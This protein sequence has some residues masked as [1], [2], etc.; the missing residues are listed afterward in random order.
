VLT[1]SPRSVDRLRITMHAAQ[2]HAL[3]RAALVGAGLAA[4]VVAHITAVGAGGPEILPIAPLIWCALIALAVVCG[5]R[6]EIYAPRSAVGT[7]AALVAA[8]MVF[9]A[10]ASLAPWALG[11]AGSGMRMSG[12]AMLTAG[13]VWPHALAA[14]VLGAVLVRA[15]R[16]LERA[17]AL[18]RRAVA[19]LAARHA[20]PRPERVFRT[21]RITLTAQ[22]A[23]GSRPARGPPRLRNAAAA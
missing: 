4:T 10:V 23:G 12:I 11:F 2:A 16:L 5:R 9:H 7:C 22:V 15:D 14:A 18:V 17:V 13:A 3:R 20:W 21:D 1:P 6:A 19:E 8:Q